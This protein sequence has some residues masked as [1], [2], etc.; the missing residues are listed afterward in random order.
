MITLH[1]FEEAYTAKRVLSKAAM[2]DIFGLAP[3]E[4]LLEPPEISDEYMRSVKDSEQPAFEILLGGN[5]HI[6]EVERDLEKIQGYDPEFG[7]KYGRWPNITERVMAWDSARFIDEEW[8][9]VYT[10]NNNSGGPTYYIPKRLWG[11]A[12]MEEQVNASD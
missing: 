5:I 12:Q 9:V 8:A 1:N 3:V 11:K 2:V 7:E 10:V 4:S 6:A